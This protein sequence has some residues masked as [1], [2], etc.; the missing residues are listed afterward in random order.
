[1]TAMVEPVAA[2]AAASGA[3]G[4]S[5]YAAMKLL[6]AAQRRAMFEI[7]GF[8]RAVDDVADDP[9]LRAM[10][11]AELEKWRD[12]VHGL[13]AGRVSARTQPM[14]EPVA[15]F[16]LAERDFQAV[17]DGMEM[18]VHDD[19]RAPSLEVLDT[20][21]DRVA[22]AVGRL[23]V[24]VFGLPEEPGI[25]LARVLGRALQLTNILRDLDE[26]AERGRLYLPREFLD[27]AGITSAEPDVVLAHPA[28]ADAC[29]PLAE[30]A[31]GYF[32]AA[33][34]ILADC[35]RRAGRAPRLMAKVYGALLRRLIERGWQAP[36]EPV[37]L[38]R[39][40]KLWMLLRHGLV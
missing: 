30:L 4:S 21:C 24:R 6:P 33:E 8:C 35:P 19:I 36:R 26:D 5:F 39:G 14:A 9:G 22:S 37:R 28:I 27:G 40:A 15:R 25:E 10:R 11:L 2:R 7:Y 29:A 17:I 38:S 23:S 12:E 13:Y 1:M 18:D 34:Q 20:Y 32:V 3:Q 31:L 16:G